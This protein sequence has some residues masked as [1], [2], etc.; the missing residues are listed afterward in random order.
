MMV[1]KILRAFTLCLAVSTFRGQ[2]VSCG[3]AKTSKDAAE[4]FGGGLLE[5]VK[6]LREM[7]NATKITKKNQPNELSTGDMAEVYEDKEV[8]ATASQEVLVFD[9]PTWHDSHL[10]SA[11]VFLQEFCKD[12]TARKFS[13]MLVDKNYLPLSWICKYLSFTLQSMTQFYIPTYAPGA[14]SERGTITGNFYEGKLKPKDFKAYAKWLKENIPAIIGSL[15][16]M[17]NETL[18]VTEKERETETPAG[19]LKYGFVCKDAWWKFSSSRENLKSIIEHC[20]DVMKDLLAC[21]D[22]VSKIS[23]NVLTESSK[24]INEDMQNETVTENPYEISSEPEQL[25]SKPSFIDK[26]SEEQH[27]DNGEEQLK[28]IAEQRKE[29]VAR[30][31]VADAPFSLKDMTLFLAVLEDSADVDPEAI[32]KIGEKIH[33]FLDTLG[34]H[35]EDV[36]S[37]IEKLKANVHGYTMDSFYGS[38]KLTPEERDAVKRIF[39]IIKQH[40]QPKVKPHDGAPEVSENA[41]EERG[42]NSNV[43]PQAEDPPQPVEPAEKASSL[44]EDPENPS[45]GF[46]ETVQNKLSEIYHEL[47]PLCYFLLLVIILTIC[48]GVISGLTVNWDAAKHVMM[49]GFALSVGIS[50]AIVKLA[51]RPQYGR[52]R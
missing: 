4:N 15:E 29:L 27:E 6:M 46:F 37:S 48:S 51:F 35:G 43:K 25:L 3:E 22:N 39:D 18:E 1:F 50:L 44:I 21:L 20:L 32:Q 45:K 12:T 38:N 33:T 10:A 7:L 17:H 41:A 11:V 36:K 19:P 40:G 26:D 52:R 42:K 8:P 5:Q 47:K 30:L 24:G 23:T 13:E 34:I 16:R 9:I 31:L 14:A 2:C 49:Y 28:T